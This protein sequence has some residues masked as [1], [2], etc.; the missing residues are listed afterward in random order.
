VLLND[1][2]KHFGRT[3]VIPDTFRIN[4]RDRS[5]RA[6][7]KAIRFGAI[8]LRVRAAGQTE[9]LEPLFQIRP[10]VESKFLG[11]ALRLRL[12]GAKKNVA[13]DV[14]DAERPG[15]LAKF[16]H[17]RSVL[18]SR[19]ALKTKQRRPFDP[20]APDDFRTCAGRE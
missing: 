12:V 19:A 7:A 6:D 20:G 16:I 13:R 17:A 3:G 9:F 5:A 2:L 4:D 15:A 10:R 8:H 11:A 18:Q 1:A 14:L